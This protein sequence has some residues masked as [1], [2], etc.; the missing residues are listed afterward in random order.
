MTIHIAKL[1]QLV[2]LKL[3][4]ALSRHFPS[5]SQ[6][7]A[8]MNKSSLFRGKERWKKNSYHKKKYRMVSDAKKTCSTRAPVCLKGSLLLNS[9][10]TINCSTLFLCQKAAVSTNN[11]PTLALSFQKHYHY[12]SGLLLLKW[13]LAFSFFHC[14][15]TKW[16]H[17]ARYKVTW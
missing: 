17:L 13:H 5:L 1:H 6:S 16:W 8:N 9:R 7:S 15:T 2:L 3:C 12:T 11:K 4:C 10:N 14:F